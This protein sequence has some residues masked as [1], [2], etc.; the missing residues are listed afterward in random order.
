MIEHDLRMSGAR[1]GAAHECLAWRAL[2][3]RRYGRLDAV[4]RRFRVPLHNQIPD[5]IDPPRRHIHHH[6]YWSFIEVLAEHR[7]ARIGRGRGDH[8][9][10]PGAE[11]RAAERSEQNRHQRRRSA[12]QGYKNNCRPDQRAP[13]ATNDEPQLG[14]VRH[15]GFLQ[16]TGLVQTSQ[17]SAAASKA[18]D[19]T[20][21]DA[22]EQQVIRGLLGSGDVGRT[23]YI[24]R[25]MITSQASDCDSVRVCGKY[26]GSR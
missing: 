22:R 15:I 12:E 6:Q 7:Q 16:Y 24:L 17:R 4:L 5:F 26:R 23:K 3:E 18:V 20:L 19:V 14:A 13:Q 2:R 11:Y 25:L 21:F 8:S 1:R 9:R 10:Y